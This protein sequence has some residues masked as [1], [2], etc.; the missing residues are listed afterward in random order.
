MKIEV[1]CVTQNF[2]DWLPFFSSALALVVGVTDDST[3]SLNLF[4]ALVT[5]PSHVHSSHRVTH[6]SSS[7]LGKC[8]T[9][10]FC[11]CEKPTE[12]FLMTKHIQPVSYEWSPI[13][14]H[15]KN[16]NLRHKT[17][18]TIQNP[19]S[20]SEQLVRQTRSRPYNLEQWEEKSGES[21]TSNGSGSRS[22][23]RSSQEVRLSLTIFWYKY[24][25]C[26]S[27]KRKTTSRSRQHKNLSK[28]IASLNDD[29]LS[30]E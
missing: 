14:M 17:I 23:I 2:T 10:C 16:Q 11:S 1:Q 18:I 24:F 29:E 28:V 7:A 15:R 26:F 6:F 19:K 3:L 30:L 27:L 9:Y 12:H 5:I 25:G 21:C 13:Q 4:T 8:H 22:S 20:K